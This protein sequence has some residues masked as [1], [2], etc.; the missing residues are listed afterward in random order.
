MEPSLLF[1]FADCEGSV[2]QAVMLLWA[3][4]IGHA[5]GDFPLQG[6]FVA[7]W[8]NRNFQP[9]SGPRFIPWSYMM[10]VHCLIQSGMVWVISGSFLFA[11]IEFVLHYAIDILKCEEKSGFMLD[12]G[13]HLATKLAFVVIIYFGL[14]PKEWI[15]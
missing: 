13:L 4:A 15:W 5:L 8:K 6:E 7:Q 3:F 12:Q 14:L 11:I 10:G 2:L 1:Q 9:C